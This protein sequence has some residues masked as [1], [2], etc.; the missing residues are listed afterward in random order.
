MTSPA[1]TPG[2][3]VIAADGV[4]LGTL[5]AVEGGFLRL[6][7]AATPPIVWVNADLVAGGSEGELHLILDRDD[8]HDG[9]IALSPARQREYGTLEALS[10]LARRN[11]ENQRRL[12]S[13]GALTATPEGSAT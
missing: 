13:G 5:V 7:R 10:L 11:R 12:S 6:R 1:Y 3:V 8:L 4:P 2:A 9:V